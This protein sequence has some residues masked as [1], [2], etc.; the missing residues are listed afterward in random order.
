MHPF[1]TSINQK[2]LKLYILSVFM[3]LSL[4]YLQ[5][6]VACV[7]VCVCCM[8]V[9]VCM[10][11]VCMLH[12]CVCHSKQKFTLSIGKIIKSRNLH[13]SDITNTCLL[14]KNYK[15]IR[16]RNYRRFD[17]AKPRKK[18]EGLGDP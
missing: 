14:W 5:V 1:Q 16:F 3:T 11:Y 15:I 8:C 17:E 9:C 6:F 13:T 2:N 18:G 10:L 7:C 4:S 12:V